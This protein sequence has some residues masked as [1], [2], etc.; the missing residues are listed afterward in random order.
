M[1]DA[2]WQPDLVR[3]RTSQSGSEA[4]LSIELQLPRYISQCICLARTWYYLLLHFFDSYEA[5]RSFDMNYCS[6]FIGTSGRKTPADSSIIQYAGTQTKLKDGN[7]IINWVPTSTIYFTLCLS[8]THAACIFTL[9][10]ASMQLQKDGSFKINYCSTFI[11]IS[12]RKT[13]ADKSIVECAG[14]QAKAA[15]RLDYQLSTFALLWQQQKD[16]SFKINYCSTFIGFL[17]RKTSADKSIVECAHAQAKGVVERVEDG[18]ASIYEAC[19]QREWRISTK[20]TSQ[21]SYVVPSV[22]L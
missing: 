15:A 8:C 3:T 16:G 10:I 6:T 4:T 17:G 9:F 7:E 20:I 1:K 13:S 22:G 14:T 2:H 11:G 21:E 18:G 19:C 12:E 5:D